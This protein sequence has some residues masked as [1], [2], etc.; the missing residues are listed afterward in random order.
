MK[1]RIIVI[2]LGS[3]LLLSAL[4]TGCGGDAKP[5]E[6]KDSPAPTEAVDTEKPEAPKEVAASEAEKEPEKE[7][8][9]Q[10]E[11]KKSAGKQKTS[12]EDAEDGNTLLDIEP[13]QTQET[14]SAP[15]ASKPTTTPTPS[16][17]PTTAP[18]PSPKPT[19]APTPTI[20][21]IGPEQSYEL[22]RIPVKMN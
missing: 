15:A 12:S 6:V 4:L 18:T 16:P 8:E 1:K 10:A 3:V 9:K 13:S 5:A 11:D 22:P 14:T 19:I 17:K 20:P 2:V 21:P 7:S